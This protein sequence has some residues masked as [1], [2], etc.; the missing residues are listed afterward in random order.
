MLL[1][2]GTGRAWLQASEAGFFRPDAEQTEIDGL[3]GVNP[4]F[5]GIELFV[6]MADL[7][8]GT[9]GETDGFRAVGG[10]LPEIKLVVK[11]DSGVIFGPTGDAKGRLLLDRKVGLAVDESGPRTLGDVHNGA[12]GSVDGPVVIIVEV[13]E[14]A[15]TGTLL[16]IVVVVEAVLDF[17]A[18]TSGDVHERNVPGGAPDGTLHGVSG[19]VVRHDEVL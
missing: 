15:A 12:R 18:D 9:I 6:T 8:G 19:P 5:F 2:K 1:G 4:F 14:V 7:L 11:D 13:K 10:N 17:C 16:E 3:A